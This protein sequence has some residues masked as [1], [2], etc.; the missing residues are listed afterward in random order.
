MPR[1]PNTPVPAPMVTTGDIIDGLR[2]LGVRSGDGLFVHSSLSA[3]GWV[4]G[5]A[6]SVCEA[7]IG[8]VGPEGTAAVPTFTWSLYH[9]KEQVEFDV[10]RDPTEDGCIPETFRK[11][12]E[13]LRSE[14]VCHSV[15][16]VG[17]RAAELMG[18]GIHP[19]A[20]GSSMYQ[21]YALDF[22]YVFMGCGFNVCSALHTVEEVLQVPYRYYRHFKGSTII[23]MDGSFAHS[24]ALEHLRY[25]PYLNDFEKME[26]VCDRAGLLRRVRVGRACLIAA[27]ARSI[28]DL[29]LEL[30]GNDPGYL[31]REDSRRYLDTCL[32]RGLR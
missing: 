31:L 15:A 21:L 6:E 22:W 1:H 27:K 19:F 8:A 2:S 20:K 25:L 3:F 4:D 16:A 32:Q 11:R 23:R 26:A 29:G 17:R 30:V 9:D 5:G 12:P 10:R 7:M 13:A 24:R 18:D 28:I 14:H